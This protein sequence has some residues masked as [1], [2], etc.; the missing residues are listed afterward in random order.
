MSIKMWVR[1]FT[2]T[3]V[4]KTSSVSRQFVNKSL[5]MGAIGCNVCNAVD[6]KLFPVPFRRL[7]RK[8]YYARRMPQSW[9][10]QNSYVMQVDTLTTSTFLSVLTLW[11]LNSH[12]CVY[13]RSCSFYHLW[14]HQFKR[15]HRTRTVFRE[16]S[17]RKTVSFE[18]QIK[19][20]NKYPSILSPQMSEHIFAPNVFIILQIFLKEGY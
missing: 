13:S 7:S 4:A 9:K 18:E 16:R 20:M 3:Y 8:R 12:V 1:K 5:S 14:R 6:V 10:S 17:T 15:H 11:V 2:F 19:S